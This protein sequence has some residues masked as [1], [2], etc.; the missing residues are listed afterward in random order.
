ML[1]SFQT[2][3]RFP[4]QLTADL[5]N[6]F[7]KKHSRASPEDESLLSCPLEKVSTRTAQP[8]NGFDF[9]SI[10]DVIQPISLRGQGVGEWGG[11][12]FLLLLPAAS[13]LN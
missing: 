3:A 1:T 12:R 10:P 5:K 2:A 8:K 13:G 9:T 11:L 6:S 7:A 4:F